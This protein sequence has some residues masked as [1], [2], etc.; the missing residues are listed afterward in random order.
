[1]NSAALCLLVFNKSSLRDVSG[2]VN[3]HQ[4]SSQAPLN[5]AAY[6][7]VSERSG[8]TTR[9]QSSNVITNNSTNTTAQNKNLFLGRMIKTQLFDQSSTNT[10]Y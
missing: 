10:Q 6:M 4:D 8:A 2:I 9:R 7:A 1:M 3:G 5:R